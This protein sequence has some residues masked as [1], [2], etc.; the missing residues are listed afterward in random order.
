M[1]MK[2]LKDSNPM[3]PKNEIDAIIIEK[4]DELGKNI[5]S[6]NRDLASIGN[7]FDHEEFERIESIEG[8]RYKQLYR[9]P[10]SIRIRNPCKNVMTSNQ[11]STLKAVSSNN[12]T[13][14]N[15][16]HNQYTV[17]SKTSNISNKD[18]SSLGFV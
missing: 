6:F 15:G 4:S 14:S 5:Q 13:V 9:A 3:V 16:Y 8:H 12:V 17:D 10:S 2:K 18:S 1:L 11:Y 7:S